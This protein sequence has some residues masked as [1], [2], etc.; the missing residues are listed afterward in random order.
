M[1]RF[2]VSKKILYLILKTEALVL[3]VGPNDGVCQ[4][5]LFQNYIKYL[6]GH[7]D[8]DFFCKIL[9]INNFR[10][11]LIDISAKRKHWCLCAAWFMYC[12]EKKPSA[13]AHWLFFKAKLLKPFNIS[14]ITSKNV[15]TTCDL[16][17]SDFALARSSLRSLQK[18][19]IFIENKYV[20][21]EPKHPKKYF[22]LFWK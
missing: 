19:F 14:K 18:V 7:Y 9:K 3:P 22:I 1:F 8:P 17:I 6:F 16:R 21:T 5:F 4:C 2:K 11:E 12:W 20:C 15:F 13:R 10:G